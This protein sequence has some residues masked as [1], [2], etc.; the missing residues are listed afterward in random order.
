MEKHIN[1]RIESIRDVDFY[2]QSNYE[3]S[4][5]QLGIRVE[6]KDMVADGDTKT[7]T[8][9]TVVEF[10]HAYET[11][12]ANTVLRY[13]NET[14]FFVDNFSEIFRFESEKYIFEKS[15]LSFL[16]NIIVP[17]IRGILV[18]K[19][20]GTGLAKCYLPIIDSN[21]I[22]LNSLTSARK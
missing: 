19:T 18:T 15:L 21:Q 7:V 16:F 9:T 12:N 1:L 4:P 10:V 20:T 6:E 2:I 5:T 8:L 11:D 14:S 13:T 22:V 17:T 3:I